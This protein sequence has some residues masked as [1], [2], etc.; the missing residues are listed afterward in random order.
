MAFRLPFLD[1]PAPDAP[2][3]GP[4]RPVL[5]L[6]GPAL[7]RA[8]EALIAGGE[9]QGG[10]ENYASGLKSKAALFEQ[11]LGGGRAVALDLESFKL[12][13]AR[14]APVRRRVGAPLERR[15]F[16]FFREAIAELLDAAAIAENAD[17]RIA[18]FGARFPR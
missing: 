11:K 18:A 8:F 9:E 7:T 2:A 4:A 17:A 6:G 3:S 12:I 5:D 1:A 10:I 13:C 15:G 16:E 14:M